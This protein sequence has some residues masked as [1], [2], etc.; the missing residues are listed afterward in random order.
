MGDGENMSVQDDY[1]LEL[2][3]AAKTA[4]GKIN[5]LEAII[6]NAEQEA[7]KIMYG[8]FTMRGCKMQAAKVVNILCKKGK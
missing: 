3:T 8:E 1:I 5:K 6:E 4:E 7:R 2:E